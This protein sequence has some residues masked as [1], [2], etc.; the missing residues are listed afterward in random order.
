M[1][2]L[3]VSKLT[4]KDGVKNV[5][6]KLDKRLGGYQSITA[7]AAYENFEHFQQSPEM[8]MKDFINKFESKQ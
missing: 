3:N 7:Y 6:S 1:L 8:N 5:I 2:E 4:D